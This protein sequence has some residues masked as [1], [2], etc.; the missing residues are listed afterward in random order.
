SVELL[1]DSGLEDYPS[2]W[3]PDGR[4]IVIERVNKESKIDIMLFSLDDPGEVRPLVQTP[5]REGGGKVSPD[6]RWLAYHSD[7]SGA[8]E[9]YVTSMSGQ[10][11]KWQVST[12]GGVYPIW[13]ADGRTL[14]YQAFGGQVFAAETSSSGETFR[15]GSVTALI[16]G[17]DPTPDGYNYAVLPN[18]EKFLTI[19]GEE[20]QPHELLNLVVGWTAELQ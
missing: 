11:R 5:F 2:D 1:V 4:S 12:D 3:S 19:R 18:R 10:G 17:P 20:S 9:I 7:E 16:E 13:R 6:G 15:V 8:W 14:Y